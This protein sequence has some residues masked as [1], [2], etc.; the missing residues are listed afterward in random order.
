[1]LREK[2]LDGGA[3]L[4]L[5]RELR[6]ITAAAGATLIVNARSDIA[7][8]CEAEGVHLGGD[9]PRVADV[10]ARFGEALWIGASIHGTE[11]C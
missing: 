11:A 10:R 2:D 5:A 9:A 7:I 8:A 6:D 4:R 3:L 1:M